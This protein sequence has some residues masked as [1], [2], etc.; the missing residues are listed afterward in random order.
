MARA[1]KGLIAKGKSLAGRLTGFSVPVFGVQWTPPA[2]ERNI[3][4]RLLQALEDR[5]VLFVP[6]TLEVPEEVTSS[7]LRVR[8]LLT[9]TLQELPDNSAA[10]GSIR[11]MRAACRKFQDEPRPN[12]RNVH[13]RHHGDWGCREDFSPGFFVALGEL[14]ASFGTHIAALACQYGIDV[15]D[16]L[17]SILPAIDEV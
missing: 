2:D 3:I 5:R 14:R 13:P 8:E 4:R 9:Q 12:Y 16:D 1:S 15:E 6:Y 11:A 10:C 7:I 17:A